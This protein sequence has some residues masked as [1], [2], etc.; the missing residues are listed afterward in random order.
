MMK[1]VVIF[2]AGE[3]LFGAIA[4]V[5]TLLAVFVPLLVFLPYIVGPLRLSKAR[6]A[7][8]GEVL[9]YAGVFLVLAISYQ[10]AV[11]RIVPRIF[12]QHWRLEIE[13]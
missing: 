5:Y 4:M 8:A 12:A 10:A 6:K 7:K 1:R 3:N 9:F 11:S 2:V 13:W